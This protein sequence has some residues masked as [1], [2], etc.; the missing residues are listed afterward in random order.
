M[1]TLASKIWKLETGEIVACTGRL[2]TGL[3]MMRWYEAGASHDKWP[4]WQNTD[5]WSRLI[6]ACRKGV[7]FYEHTSYPIPVLDPFMAWGSGQDFAMGAMA[8]GATAKEAVEI[9]CRFSVNCGYGVEEY[10]L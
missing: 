2:D 5:H 8:M 1:R 9:A 3:A 4:T 7:K 6:V 10:E